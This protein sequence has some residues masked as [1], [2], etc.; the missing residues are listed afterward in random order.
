MG[1]KMFEARY[2]ADVINLKQYK[3]EMKGKIYCRYCGTPITYVREHIRE[4]GECDVRVSAYFRLTNSKKGSHADGCK[5]ITENEIKDIYAKCCNEEDLMSKVGES[6]IVR[7]HI[8]TDFL[9]EVEKDNKDISMGSKIKPSTLKY[10]KSGDKAAYITTLKRIL[11]L[12]C[13]L[14]MEGIGEIK[15]KIKLKFYNSVTKMYDEIPWNSFF[16]E[17]DKE[18]YLRAFKYL[19]KKVYHPVVFC[20]KVKSVKPPTENFKYYTT[21]IGFIEVEKNKYVSLNVLFDAPEMYMEMK[22]Y[23]GCNVAIYGSEAYAKSVRTKKSE[24]SA[25]REYLNISMRICGTDQVLKIDGF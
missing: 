4:V 5:Y 23:E 22:D 21:S 17:Y 2:G 6:Y 24:K 25:E 11:K 16:F 8:L 14:D 3:E 15:D 9:D 13:Q 19:S 10:I 20:G 18:D 7:L 12:R 1:I